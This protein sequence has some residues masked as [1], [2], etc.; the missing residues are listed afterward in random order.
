MIEKLKIIFGIMGIVI[1]IMGFFL[2]IDAGKMLITPDLMG[3][4]FAI[5]MG[6]KLLI[7]VVLFFMGFAILD[8]FQLRS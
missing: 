2:I 8:P 3:F 1:V 4:E 6:L 7:G 5:F